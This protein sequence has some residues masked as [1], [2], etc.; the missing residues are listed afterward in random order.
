MPKISTAWQNTWH[1]GYIRG[2]KGKITLADGCFIVQRSQW[3]KMNTDRTIYTVTLRNIIITHFVSGS[4]ASYPGIRWAGER[5]RTLL[6]TPGYE[7]TGS[8]A[9]QGGESK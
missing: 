6:R 9:R 3:H 8:Q 2:R 4:L 7:A 1:Q 5:E